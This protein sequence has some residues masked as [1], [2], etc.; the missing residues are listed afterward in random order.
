MLRQAILP[1]GLYLLLT[2][3]VHPWY[4]TLVLALLP[5]YWPAPGEALAIRRWLWPWVYFM[6]FEAFTYLVYSGMSAPTGLVWIQTAAY[7]PFWGLLLW[8]SRRPASAPA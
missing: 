6:F 4:L 2:P 1:F 7:L 3:T 8:A 5:F